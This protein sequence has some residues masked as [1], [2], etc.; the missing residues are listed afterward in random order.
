M[1]ENEIGGARGF[2]NDREI[3]TGREVVVEFTEDGE[4]V[5]GRVI[6]AMHA[7]EKTELIL[8]VGSGSRNIPFDEFENLETIASFRGRQDE[9]LPKLTS[10]EKAEFDVQVGRFDETRGG[11][12]M[13][14]RWKRRGIIGKIGEEKEVILDGKKIKIKIT[15]DLADI[16][17]KEGLPCLTERE[18]SILGS[19]SV[20]DAEVV[21]ICRKHGLQMVDKNDAPGAE[22]DIY[23]LFG[24]DDYRKIRIGLW[25]GD[26]GV[27]IMG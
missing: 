22:M 19:G 12:L 3:P 21:E 10:L 16:G 27:E 5:T 1:V 7:E 25:K 6:G 26:F 23:V 14:Q 15:P 4:P 13:A 2:I 17:P 9:G 18:F 8:S 11:W 24:N 20:E